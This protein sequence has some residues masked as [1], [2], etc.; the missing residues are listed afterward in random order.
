MSATHSSASRKS[1]RGISCDSTRQLKSMS[2]RKFSGEG[3][4]FMEG[5]SI[6][7]CVPRPL[8]PATILARRVE[9]FSD[10]MKG[11]DHGKECADHM[12]VT[13]EGFVLLPSSLANIIGPTQ[14]VAA[15]SAERSFQNP[16]LVQYSAYRTA[17]R[18]MMLTKRGAVR[19]PSKL[20][21]VHAWSSFL[22]GTSNQVKLQC[23]VYFMR[24]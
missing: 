23:H 17:I 1:Q 16:A 6:A 14:N 24:R 9:N 8:L 5:I 4:V 2:V 11:C 22:T 20:M 3:A 13:K 19:G 7:G 12:C 10:Y 21:G 18:G 15:M